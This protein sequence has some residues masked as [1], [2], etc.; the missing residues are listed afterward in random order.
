MILKSINYSICIFR[1]KV[2]G[3]HANAKTDTQM[4]QN[5]EDF[6][7]SKIK[8]N[9]SKGEKYPELKE[10]I[11]RAAAILEHPESPGLISEPVNSSYGKHFNIKRLFLG[12]VEFVEWGIYYHQ[13][14]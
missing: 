12:C 8:P 13:S 2:D 7:I 5:S 9:S 6:W 4:G 14:I 1:K 10:S 3:I 11:L